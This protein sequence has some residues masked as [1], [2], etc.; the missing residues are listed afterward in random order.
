MRVQLSNMKKIMKTDDEWRKILTLEQF[1][2][3]RK[4]RTE[5]PNS[6]S[7][8]KNKGRGTYSCVACGNKLFKSSEKFDSK[9][10][11]PSFFEPFSDEALEYNE[12]SAFGIQ[13]T[14]VLCAKCGGHLGHVF[15]DGPA[16]TGKRFC[17]NGVVLKFEK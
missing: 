11:W 3:L 2:I 5:V 4:K 15:K 6:C 1:D 13:R 7:L 17:I 14:E 9:S 10:G 8:L 12:D 16:P